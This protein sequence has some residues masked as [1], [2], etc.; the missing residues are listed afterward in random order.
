MK[1]SLL[2]AIFLILFLLLNA[3]TFDDEGLKENVINGFMKEG[4]ISSGKKRK[5]IDGGK[6][7]TWKIKEFPKE[8]V[9]WIN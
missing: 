6:Q 7:R 5:Q 2:L 8:S 1:R 3:D 4:L 9:K